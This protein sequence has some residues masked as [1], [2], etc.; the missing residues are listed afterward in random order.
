M[1]GIIINAVVVLLLAIL[2]IFHLIWNQPDHW[3]RKR[4]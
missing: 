3:K 2:L 1:V 4:R